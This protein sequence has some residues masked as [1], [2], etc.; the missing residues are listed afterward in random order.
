MRTVKQM[1]GGDEKKS[2]DDIW[3][4]TYKEL[5]NQ[6]YEGVEKGSEWSGAEDCPKNAAF[7]LYILGR[8]QG[9]GRSRVEIRSDK[10]E[11][12][13]DNKNAAYAMIALDILDENHTTPLQDL[14][15]AVQERY[16]PERL[17]KKGLLARH[18]QYTIA[19]ALF[20][21]K[22]IVKRVQ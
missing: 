2:W 15:C 18:H 19:F 7:G 22:K 11:A 17:K 10:V 4:K 6:T 21:G 12:F 8:I 14:W 1:K 16:D 3:Y 13:L 9:S 20:H 5:L